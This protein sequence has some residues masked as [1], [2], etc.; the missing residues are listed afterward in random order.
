MPRRSRR[1]RPPL[2]ELILSIRRFLRLQFGRN[3]YVCFASP[4]LI[5]RLT[6]LS[7]RFIKVISP[8]TCPSFTHPHSPS[9]C[10]KLHLLSFR[11][12]MSQPLHDLQHLKSFYLL[13]SH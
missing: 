9:H 2:P 6:R 5:L 4:L 13:F 10:D 7:L 3:S 11:E 1:T 12:R 8:Q